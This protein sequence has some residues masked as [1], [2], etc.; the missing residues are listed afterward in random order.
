MP[1]AYAKVLPTTYYRDHFEEFLQ[2][3]IS[4]CRHLLAPEHH[5][6]I[7]TY[8][9]LEF[10]AQC[11][12]VRMVNRATPYIRR[13]TLH[14]QEIPDTGIAIDV[15]VK[16]GF[17]RGVTEPDWPH[18][19]SAHTKAELIS[20]GGARE[21][22]PT[23]SARK[24]VWITSLGTQLDFEV[25]QSQLLSQQWL[26]RNTDHHLDYLLYLFFG[27]CRGQ[28]KQF[29]LRDLGVMRTRRTQGSDPAGNAA[30]FADI[31]EAQSAFFHARL[32]EQVTQCDC[33]ELS[34]LLADV[35]YLPAAIGAVAQ[36]RRD[37][38]LQ[39]L[40]L[41]S[42]ATHRE[43]ALQTLEHSEHPK[44]IEKWAREMYATGYREQ[45]ER[46]L[47]DILEDPATDELAL[48]AEDFYR[49]KF[50][51]KR[52]SLVTKMLRDASRSVTLDESWLG[53]A[54]QGVA[55]Q[56]AA[57]EIQ[58]WFVE[59]T[60]WRAL[61]GILFWEELFTPQ[62]AGA[63]TEFDR[64]PQSIRDGSFGQLHS[65]LVTQKLK[66]LDQP[67]SAIRF[68]AAQVAQHFDQPNGVF[69]WHDQLLDELSILLR[70]APAGAVA[71]VMQRMVQDYL[72]H[73]D[74]FPDLMVLEGNALRFEEVKA[75]GDQLRRNQLARLRLLQQ[76]G[77]S[78]EITQVQWITDP[79]QVYAVI[80]V[81]TTG[82]RSANHRITEIA[83]VLVQGG[84]IVDQW[85][86]LINPQRHIPRHIT[87]ITGIDDKMV[88]DAP[89]FDAIAQ[90][91]LQRLSGAVFVA[92]NVNFDY[93]FVRAE[94]TR[95]ELD[96]RMPKLCTVRQARKYFPKLSSYS[97]GH[98][99]RE[100]DVRLDN[101]HRA[102][103]DA[104]AAAE[105][106][107]MCQAR[108]SRESC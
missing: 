5:E 78:V 36:E 80:D 43:L 34:R 79:N 93:G 105:L 9:D 96:L 95:L 90:Q 13:N 92:H 17:A 100:L 108:A 29:S 39:R 16:T 76:A 45:V 51:S 67:E 88:A 21:K 64:L 11:L 10:S 73:K 97:L 46:K 50:Q 32:A 63:V 69:S 7:Q 24:S 14:Y 65:E 53:Q 60:L 27:H 56:Y 102:L 2:A 94:L 30:R 52:V 89:T 91:L 98:L 38:Y 84:E 31:A 66:L 57:A 18:I 86:S 104:L 37:L 19:L 77:F 15:L 6:F 71:K 61:F 23:K 28:L 59:N 1:A 8:R 44:A 25:Y 4:Q 22:S 70:H 87:K 68:L 82:G 58:T 54:E 48:F 3:V 101:H 55:Q 40:G 81:E 33:N 41:S 62:I 20:L 35:K 103:D 83:V 72:A 99:C 85:S 107:R 106:L 26:V 74:G 12:W 49:L 47:E 75:P 42:L